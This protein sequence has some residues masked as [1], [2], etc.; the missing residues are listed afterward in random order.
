MQ[1]LLVNVQVPLL[2]AF[3]QLARSPRRRKVRRAIL[4]KPVLRVDFAVLTFLP[5][6]TRDQDI[7]L[8]GSRKTPKQCIIDVLANEA[9]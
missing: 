8:D 2:L 4:C 9:V 5:R 7:A 1:R 3:L 6:S